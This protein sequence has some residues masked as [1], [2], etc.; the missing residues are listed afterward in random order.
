MMTV[1]GVLFL[2][3]T[4]SAAAAERPVSETVPAKYDGTVSIELISGTV[5]F[6]GWER[7][8]VQIEGTLEDDVEGLDIDTSANRVSIEVE[9]VDSPGGLDRVDA[10]L[11]IRLPAGSRVEAESVSADLFVESVRGPV[12]IESVNGK[13]RIRGD[14]VEVDASTVSSDIEVASD[15]ELRE[16][17]F[18]SV[19]G[20][21][22]F[23]GRLAGDGRFDFEAVSGNVTLRI[24]AGTVA[25]FE[26]ET[27]SGDIDNELGPAATKTSDYVPAKELRFST[28][29][30]GARVSIE[31]FSGRV[32]LLKR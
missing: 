5:K 22:E 32:K 21:I 18:Q 30:G 24:D 31:S 6:V 8:E 29:S 28:G 25:S 26:V 9:L 12:T 17:R 11:E 16:G 19:S 3:A 2:F 20:N 13:V 7:D 4:A 10:D 15:A 1:V 14:V 23:E 27:F